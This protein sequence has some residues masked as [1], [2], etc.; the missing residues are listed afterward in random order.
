MDDRH[1]NEVLEVILQEVR[2]LHGRFDRLEARV[3]IES[4]SAD[5]VER[6]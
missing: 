3:W 2:S 6:R 4:T 1:V 5:L